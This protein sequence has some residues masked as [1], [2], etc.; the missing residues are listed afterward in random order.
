MERKQLIGL[1]LLMA[2]FFLWTLSSAP[3]KEELEK[4]RRTRDSLAMVENQPDSVFETK[5]I[6]AASDSFGLDDSLYITE[7][8]DSL[9][10][11]SE[12]SV[13]YGSFAP[14]VDGTEKDVTLE[15]EKFKI[16]FTNKGGK[17]TE[18]LLKNHVMTVIDTSGEETKAPVIML[19][20]ADNV[21]NYQ[22]PINGAL[23]KQ[24]NTEDLFFDAQVDGNS[25]IFTAPTSNGGYFRQIYTI[26]PDDYA[27]DYSIQ[28]KG[29]FSDV[30]PGKNSVKLDFLNHLTKYE[31]G[32]SYEQ[33]LS[34]VY[35]KQTDKKTDYCSCVRDDT[36]DLK[37]KEIT[38]FSHTNQFFNTSIIAK[39]LPF[40]D[41]VMSTTV[42]DLKTSDYTKIVSTELEMPIENWESGSFDMTMYIGPNEFNRLRAFNNKL[43]EIIPYGTSIFGSINRWGIRPFFDFLSK[44]IGNKG[45]VI[46]LLIFLIKMALYP[47]MYKML[48]SQAKMGALKPELAE[49]KKKYKDD[50]QKQQMETMKIYREYGVSPFGGCMPMLLQ[51][52]IWYALFR[53]FP[54]SITFRQEPF[55][56]AHD[57]STYDVFFYM[58]FEIPFFGAH[59]SLFTLLWAVTTII[60]TYYNMQNMDMGA[61]SNPMMKYI[62]YFM[63]IT[64]LAFF[65]NYASGLTAY[66]FFSNLMNITQTVVT[67]KFVFD[68]DIIRQ[69]LLAE[70]AKPKKK[71]GFGARLEE[72]MKQQQAL[73]EQKKKKK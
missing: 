48:H 11:A 53:F 23:T 33:N 69:Q 31:L 27:I 29:L 37:G 24:V 19:N 36:E 42:T 49:L 54:A 38:W 3:S 41:P 35:F 25:V 61:A 50:A 65:N 10:V 59:V 26:T 9:T 60:Y 71:S 72:A 57:L 12:N 44:Y 68:E 20:V 21:F 70:K 58:G 34:T 7:P 39:G 17:I 40:I 5:N 52:P 2:I 16:T 56:W 1:L 66:M 46:I 63:P 62:Q 32:E 43:E 6:P 15:N 18:V 14:A 30:T 55:L 64:F 28:V 8:K 67:K 22:L 47:L 73:Q 4:S 51:M 45:L 13:R